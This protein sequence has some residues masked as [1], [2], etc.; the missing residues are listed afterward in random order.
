[1][2]LVRHSLYNPSFFSHSTRTDSYRFFVKLSLVVKFIW[3]CRNVFSFALRFFFHNRWFSLSM[4]RKKEIQFLFRLDLNAIKRLWCNADTQILLAFSAVMVNLH[5]KIF[6]FQY[7]HL[8]CVGTKYV[9][10]LQIL[11]LY[12]SAIF[13]SNYGVISS[14]VDSGVFLD[15]SVRGRKNN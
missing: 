6:V 10:L 14:Y 9:V 1:M 8:F 13:T 7:M 5:S 4:C 15:C 2:F 11:F 12:T 3:C